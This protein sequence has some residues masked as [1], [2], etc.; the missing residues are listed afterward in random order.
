[1]EIDVRMN[2]GSGSVT[3][4][5]WINVD[6]QQ[7]PGVHYV[8]DVRDGLPPEWE[9]EFEMIVANHVLS[10]LTHHEL[11][12]ALA[13]LRRCLA[14]DG[15]LRILVP[16][17]LRAVQ[18]YEED[19]VAWFPLGDDLP[20]G[21]E[22]LCTFLTW[23]GESR[24]VFTAGYLGTLLVAAGFNDWA[25]GEPSESLFLPGSSITDL[26]DRERQALIVEATR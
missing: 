2:F 21:D 22:R 10:D 8:G 1:M 17:L 3:P 4:E 13:E 18:A 14:P 12:P 11:V 15:V 7:Y 19:D 25:L 24:S 16:D 20:G 9:G 23:F 6:R 26:D 5:G